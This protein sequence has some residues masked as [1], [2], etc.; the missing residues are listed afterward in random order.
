MLRHSVPRNDRSMK[1]IA[2][3]LP[4]LRG[5]GAQRVA[6]DVAN[7]LARR[8][9]PID[10]VLASGEGVYHQ[11]LDP[12]ISVIVFGVKHVRQAIFPLVSYLKRVQPATLLA[13]QRNAALVAVIASKLTQWKGNVVARETNS[14]HKVPGR[15]SD[16][17]DLILASLIKFSYRFVNCVIAPS[18]GVATELSYLPHVV[19]IPN[20]VT[21][22]EV[23]ENLDH[24]RPFILGVGSLDKQKRF[25]DLIY[26][27]GCLQSDYG[28]TNLDL[29]ILG[30]GPD[31]DELLDF[32]KKLGVND[33]LK[34]PGFV[35][36]PFKY[37]RS[38]KVFVLASGWEGMPNVLIQAMACGAPVVATDCPHGPREILANGRFGELIPVGDIRAMAVAIYRQLTRGRKPYPP[39]ALA[40]YDY[41][42]VI[43]AYQAVLTGQASP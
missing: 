42:Q 24:E 40:P 21:I 11:L 18:R 17:R 1:K 29:I 27:F 38:A 6:V 41:N 23:I 30:E 3:F 34:M 39:E 35:N 31:K 37:M 20:P 32:S 33:R 5:G 36:D 9:I 43:D 22:P 10:I 16:F 8:G 14:F 7:G 15:Y 25:N 19:T 28:M 26:A 13:I 2:I 12:S 4:S